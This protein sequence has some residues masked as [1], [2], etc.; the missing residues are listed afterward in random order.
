MADVRF[1]F[2]YANQQ[3]VLASAFLVF[4]KL[5]DR[6]DRIQQIELA[7][8]GH[9]LNFAVQRDYDHVGFAAMLP[10]QLPIRQS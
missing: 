7:R 1:R 5:L 8:P 4:L 9:N 2:F 3:Y 6:E 10:H